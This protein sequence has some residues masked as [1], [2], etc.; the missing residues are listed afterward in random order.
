MMK[1]PAGKH[2]LKLIEN[3][4]Y[5]QD[6]PGT[7]GSHYVVKCRYLVSVLCPSGSGQFRH[8]VIDGLDVYRYPLNNLGRYVAV[9]DQST[10]VPAWRAQ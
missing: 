6:P 5:P 10:S 1:Q 3:R 4:T 9:Q 2:V 8:Q 7:P